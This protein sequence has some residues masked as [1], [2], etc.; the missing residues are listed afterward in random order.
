MAKFA[1]DQI[2]RLEALPED[3]PET[4]VL[5]RHVDCLLEIP[6]DIR[7]ADETDL[8]TAR[9]ILDKDHA[10]LAEAK[11]RI[12]EFLA[13]RKLTGGARSPVLCFEGPPG[14]GK[15]TLAEAVARALGRKF[16][17]LSL[18]GVRDEAELRGHRRTYVGAHP[19][20]IAK[21]LISCGSSDPV[22]LL[23]EL[24]KVSY[25][26]GR[27]DVASAL[28]EILDPSLNRN[29][30]DHFVDF[31]IDLSKVVFIGT[32]NSIIDLPPAL[33]D[34]LEVVRFT[35]YSNQDRLSI[36]R[37]HLLP[38][39]LSEHGLEPADVEMADETLDDLIQ[40]F[41]C[42]AGVRDLERSLATLCRRAA[43]AKASN[44][45][46]CK[47]V[48]PA[49]LREIL[50]RPAPARTAKRTPTAGA[51]WGLVVAPYGGDA[52]QIEA[53]FLRPAGIP[54]EVGLTGNMGAIMRESAEAA[55][56]FVR[57]RFGDNERFSDDLHIHASCADRSKEGPSAG[58]AIALAVTSALMDLP[59]P[60][61]TAV[62]GEISLHGQVLAVGGIREKIL[63]A[64]RLGFR[65][66]VLP[67]D[68]M[69]EAT[70]L[71][72]GVLKDI[73]LKPVATADEALSVLFPSI[74]VTAS[75][76]C[77]LRDLQ[78]SAKG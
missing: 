78:H 42:E 40:T 14:V 71:G 56:S 8:E 61:D 52:F 21:G 76:H 11:E 7:S 68:N 43:K 34:R 20:R 33:K 23:D 47:P 4:A 25:E 57:L 75:G 22:I 30:L 38:K 10:Y 77:T 16:V 44:Q 17:C 12:I 70:K 3:S 72:E 29:F 37:K 58:L 6:W 65:Q 48:A 55:V 28:L 67:K 46:F 41:T 15:T 53:A 49:D 35:S 63:A 2:R 60:A 36:A 27:S 26:S 50:G 64:Q 54:K 19:G 13:V 9:A 66:V 1:L 32:A 24:D 73:E 45:E 69:D 62:T 39:C 59:T 74:V 5:I 51:V 18:G 31:P